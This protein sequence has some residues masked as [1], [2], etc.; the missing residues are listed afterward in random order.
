MIARDIPARENVLSEV[1]AVEP[2]LEAQDGFLSEAVL[3]LLAQ[4]LDPKLVARRKGGKGQSVPYLEGYQAINQANRIFGYGRWGA[5][6]VGPIGYRE[7]GRVDK[8]TGEVQPVG[9]YW[10]TV[11]VQVAGCAPRS[12]VGC[13]FTTDDSPEAHDTA[14]KAAVT[15]A[16]KRALRQFGDQF[17]N[18]LYDRNQPTRAD[19]AQELADLRSAVVALGGQLGLDEATTR[20]QV[21]RKAGRPFAELESGQLATILRAMA[22]A[23]GRAGARR[24]AERP[25]ASERVPA[26]HPRPV[27]TT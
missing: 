6:V 15:D 26:G 5:E 2:G 27:S 9:M 17:G 19:A 1:R 3:H 22:E 21:A 12:D 16:M 24:E 25:A 8:K 7:L 4:P 11:R 20:L 13:G 23:L 10:A 14:I 18:A